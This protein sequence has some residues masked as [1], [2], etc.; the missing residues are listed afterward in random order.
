MQNPAENGRAGAANPA[1]V[2]EALVDWL[3]GELNDARISA[4]DNFL[5]VGGYS[6]LF[7]KLNRF[8]GA[9][10]GV[11]LDIKTTY[12]EPLSVSVANMQPADKQ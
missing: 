7:S 3:R 6:L 9:T 12:T 10:Y 2:E 1:E 11:A 8:L 5:D 4:S